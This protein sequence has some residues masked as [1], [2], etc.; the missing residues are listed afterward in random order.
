[1]QGAGSSCPEEAAPPRPFRRYAFACDSL[2]GH[3]GRFD[4]ASELLCVRICAW[5]S[6]PGMGPETDLDL[7]GSPCR[8]RP[9]PRAAKKV[10]K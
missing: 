10:L 2:L 5:D 8:S 7:C 9:E 3:G 6:A 1:M 4:V